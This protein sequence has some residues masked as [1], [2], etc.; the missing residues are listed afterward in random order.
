MKKN[1]IVA[2]LLSAF[3]TTPALASTITLTG[4]YITASVN[5]KGV[6]NS[7]I[8]DKNGNGIFDPST[9]YVAPGTPFEAFGVNFNGSIY[10]NSNSGGTAISGSTASAG[11]NSALWTGGNTLFSLTQLFSFNANER[12]INIETTFAAL[13]D[14]MSDVLFSRAVDPDPDSLKHGTY[15][16]VNNRGLAAQNVAVTDFVGSA[17]SVSGLPLGLYYSGL[18]THNTGISSNCCGTIDPSF[19]LNGG[20]MGNNSVGDHGIGLAFNLGKLKQGDRMSWTYSYVMGDSFAKIDIP[21]NPVNT[22]AT[23]FLML[24]GLGLVAFKRRQKKA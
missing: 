24:S 12:R 20:N 7:I 2:A 9:D 15:D 4:D 10:V 21:T 13:V 22:P 1:I 5:D 16:T 14:S 3:A 11:G 6:L 8:Y 19:Y 23:A 18:I 17:G